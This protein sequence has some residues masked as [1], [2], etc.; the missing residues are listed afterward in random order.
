MVGVVEDVRLVALDVPS[1]GV[2]FA[3]WALP[4]QAS[5]NP[6]RLFVSFEPGVSGGLARVRERV[7]QADSSVRI[8]EAE[9]LADAMADSIRERRLGA[10][11]STLRRRRAGL[12]RAGPARSGDDDVEPAD[13]GSRDSAGA[14]GG[15]GRRRADAGR[16]A[17]CAVVAGLAAGAVLSAWLVPIVAARLYGVGV[18]D[19]DVWLPAVAVMLVTTVASAWLPALRATRIDP[20]VTLRDA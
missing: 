19:L 11:A 8:V 12:R 7:G 9:W 17:A 14:R 5:Y 6:I 20:A 18:Y 15:A 1:A 16:R 10:A 4:V 2:V 3:P 13:A